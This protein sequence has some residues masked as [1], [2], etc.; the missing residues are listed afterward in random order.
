M[1]SLTAISQHLE[2]M[3]PLELFKPTEVLGKPSNSSRILLPTE[4]GLV[5]WERAIKKELAA[6][7]D[8]CPIFRTCFKSVYV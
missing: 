8:F 5:S 7:F 2:I 6:A 3:R 4:H 1:G